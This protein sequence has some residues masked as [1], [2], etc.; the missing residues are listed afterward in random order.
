MPVA[1]VYRSLM[2]SELFYRGYILK[3]AR[4]PQMSII[5][6]HDC[7]LYVVHRVVAFSVVQMLRS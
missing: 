3:T 1:A 5:G 2:L 7:D 4:G 6:I